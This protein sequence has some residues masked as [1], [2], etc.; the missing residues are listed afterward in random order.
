MRLE[1]NVVQKEGA[2]GILMAPSYPVK[3]SA[4][5]KHVPEV[6]LPCL[7]YSQRAC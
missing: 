4:N 2:F 6:S 1:R 7:T 3:I 5:P